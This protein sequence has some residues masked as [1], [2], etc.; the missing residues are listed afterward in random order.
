MEM[1]NTDAFQG[2]VREVIQTI[3]GG[4]NNDDDDGGGGER[5]FDSVL[6]QNESPQQAGLIALGQLLPCWKGGV[7]HVRQLIPTLTWEQPGALQTNGLSCSKFI[8]DSS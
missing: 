2:A 4:N 7:C 8:L 1:A 6:V 3:Q 5:D